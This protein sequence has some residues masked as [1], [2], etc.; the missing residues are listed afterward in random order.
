MKEFWVYTLM[1]IGLFAGSFA[2]VLGIWLLA[3]SGGDVSTL[4]SGDVDKAIF[5][6]VIIAF[7][8]SGIASYFL[9]GRQRERFA[10]KVETRAAKVTQKMEAQRTREDVD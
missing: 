6:S 2:I 8:L 7:V 5:W 3:I 4:V 1:R 10:A 9:L